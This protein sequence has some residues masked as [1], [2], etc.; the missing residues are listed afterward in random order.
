MYVV[1]V[2][3]LVV[4]LVKWVFSMDF[5]RTGSVNSYSEFTVA[6]RPILIQKVAFY[7]SLN[8]DEKTRFENKIL[9]FLN[10]VRVTGIDTKIDDSD[11]IL[12][13]SSAIIP[14]FAFADWRYNN[15]NEVLIYPSSF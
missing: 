1:I 5:Q 11:R 9:E 2:L 12:V 14:I 8:A 15:I 4:I 7:N 3:V 13:A 10:D 6:W